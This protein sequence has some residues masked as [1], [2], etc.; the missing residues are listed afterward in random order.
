MVYSDPDP[1]RVAILTSE[2]VREKPKQVG[3]EVDD[4]LF[5]S[6]EYSRFADL[7]K[8]VTSETDGESST[9]WADSIDRSDV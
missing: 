2:K 1:D 5:L 4:D 3:P 7:F 9:D 6:E 8:Q